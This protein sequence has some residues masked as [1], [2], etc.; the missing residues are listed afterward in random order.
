MKKFHD[1][2]TWENAIKIVQEKLLPLINPG[3][4]EIP[5]SKSLGRIASEE[6]WAL[7]NVPHFLAAAVDGYAVNSKDFQSAHTSSPIIKELSDIR[8]VN[9]GDVINFPHEDAVYM[10]E[11]VIVNRDKLVFYKSISTG[12]GVRFVGEDVI[13]N[14]II[15]FRNTYI[16]P[17]HIALMRAAGV[18]YVKVYKPVKVAIIPTGEEMKQP[19][20]TLKAGDLPETSSLMVAQYVEIFGGKAS[21][22]YQPIPNDEK[23]LKKTL[24]DALEASDIVLFI[25]GSSRGKHDLIAPLIQKEGK[26]LVHG[27][28]IRP[29]KP[30]VIGIMENKP[31]IGLPGYPTATYYILQHIVKLLIQAKYPKDIP[32]KPQKEEVL[33]SAHLPS[34]G[35][36]AELLRMAVGVALDGKLHGIT[37]GSGSSKLFPITMANAHIFIPENSEGYKVGEKTNVIK[38]KDG[39]PILVMASDDI[40]FKLLISYMR[41][42]GIIV[43]YTKKGSLGAI[44]AFNKKLI[45]MAGAHLLDPQT[46]LYNK[47]FIKEPATLILMAKRQQGFIVKKGN[48]LNIKNLHDI[49]RIK[50]INREKGSGTRMLLDHLL[51][52]NNISPSNINGYTL[53]KFSHLQVAM[54]VSLGMA[55]AGF[56]IKAAADALDLDF[57]PIHTEEYHII[58]PKQDKNLEM[59]IIEILSSNSWKRQIEKLGGYDTSASG[60][61]VN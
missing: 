34:P 39:T 31:I 50:F 2:V 35:G 17:E 29:S 56:G 14:D 49:T 21:K 33:L 25:G 45:Y 52:K 48:P 20:S 5:V 10:Q 32:I 19:E 37:L 55:D 11:D 46:G 22:I 58:L 3:T 42:K 15:I 30:T 51:T 36:V 47:P 9:T 18:K 16:Q 44:N 38:V 13:K 53:E 28:R 60:K 4:E 61:V 27:I 7:R 23:E 6:V 12:K 57:I 59:S 24:Y 26:L 54:T 43:V 8:Y 1:T 40:A 41:E